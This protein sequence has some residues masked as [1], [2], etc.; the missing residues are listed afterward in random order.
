MSTCPSAPASPDSCAAAATSRVEGVTGILQP[1]RDGRR[2]HGDRRR[3][4]RPAQCADAVDRRDSQALPQRLAL[5]V[6]SRGELRRRAGRAGCDAALRRRGRARRR[7]IAS[8]HRAG[9]LAEIAASAGVAGCHLLI[10][11]EAQ[12]DRDGGEAR[13]RREE[14][15]PALDHAA[16]ELGRRRAVWRAVRR[17]A[18]RRRHSR[19]PLHRR[20]SASIACKI[21][22]ARCR[23]A[24]AEPLAANT[25]DG[26][27]RFDRRTPT[28]PE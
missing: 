13:A 5:A 28:T 8:A 19:T 10:A 23:G 7:R 4:P 12:R 2:R 22:A 26:Q 21:R 1:L 27:S 3:L 17:S 25:A 9:T 24:Q 16:R 20:R 15:D 6:R 18:D 11:D 14:P